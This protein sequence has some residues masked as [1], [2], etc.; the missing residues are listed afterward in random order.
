VTSLGSSERITNGRE[1]RDLGSPVKE[2]PSSVLSSFLSSKEIRARSPEK[3]IIP[4]GLSPAKS[5]QQIASSIEKKRESRSMEHINTAVENRAKE[6]ER[7]REEER[8][9]NEENERRRKEDDRRRKEEERRKIEERRQKEERRKSGVRD[10]REKSPPKPVKNTGTKEERR[11]DSRDS[12]SG[13]RRS[14]EEGKRSGSHH[15]TINPLLSELARK[16]GAG[17]RDHRHTDVVEELK[18]AFEL[19]ERSSPGITNRLI[20]QILVKL[21]PGLSDSRLNPA[22]DNLSLR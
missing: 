17:G 2:A 6:E 9:H 18:N 4:M 20:E 22:M 11:R 5:E 10:S 14:T 19:A 8:R 13:G 3:Q 15:A 7:K 21:Q 1:S 12:K 16:H